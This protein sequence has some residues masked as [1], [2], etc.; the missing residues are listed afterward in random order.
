ML[1]RFDITKLYRLLV[2]IVLSALTSC[3]FLRREIGEKPH[4]FN[5][6]PTKIIIFQIPGMSINHFTMSKL[7]SS[8][9]EQPIPLES[10]VCTGRLWNYSL[11]DVKPSVDETLLMQ[12]SG[13]RN[14]KRA[15][16]EKQYIWK[17]LVQ[18]GFTS[19]LYLRDAH[20]LTSNSQEISCIEK[21]PAGLVVWR[22]RPEKKLEINKE[23]KFHFLER[24]KQYFLNTVYYDKSC[25]QT[26]CHSDP[27]KTIQ[28]IYEDFFIKR[29]FHLLGIQDFTYLSYLKKG[30]FFAAKEYLQSVQATLNY[31]R[32]LV[33]E[34]LL[35]LFVFSDPIE[36]MFPPSGS[37]WKRFFDEIKVSPGKLQSE[38]LAWGASS[39]KFC[40]IYHV[41][42]L[43]DRIIRALNAE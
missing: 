11:F 34:E 33:K 37:E 27:Q 38:V 31:F 22:S 16:E 9:V 40:G 12:L 21:N 18:L 17:D 6:R 41:G 28:S 24:N 20:G 35:V 2:I 7:A 8:V 32:S 3:A 14:T 39:E 36:L 5:Q 4:N 29:D 23:L 42:N 26:K 43:K 19:G 30:D 15:C 25:D 10:A 13:D 1:Q